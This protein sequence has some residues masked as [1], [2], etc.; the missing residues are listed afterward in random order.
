MTAFEH[1]VGNSVPHQLD[2]EP[3]NP[4]PHRCR[5]ILERIFYF[6]YFLCQV[7]GQ[8][9]SRMELPKASL[10]WCQKVVGLHVPLE[11]LVDN[12]L[13]SFPNTAG[14]AY[15]AVTGCL[16]VVFPFLEDWDH[17][18]FPPC[19][20][21]CTCCPAVVE[22]LQVNLLPRWVSISFVIAS[23]P[24]DFFAFSCSL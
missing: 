2:D 4:H 19:L 8:I 9:F 12:S 10:C 7:C 16:I 17:C 23:G 11:A 6:F 1:V 3:I 24:G 22:Y 14:E 20:R 21:E 13:H 15:G 5:S 18:C